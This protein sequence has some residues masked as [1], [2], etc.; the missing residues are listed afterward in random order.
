VLQYHLS[1]IAKYHLYT[2]NEYQLY[3][4]N[5]CKTTTDIQLCID[6]TLQTNLLHMHNGMTSFK[7]KIKAS[8]AH[9]IYHY[10]LKIKV[11]KYNADI[12]FN[13]QCLTKKIIPNYANTKV[14]IT[15]PATYKTQNKAQIT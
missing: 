7:F 1:F 8:Q 9:S 4:Y 3:F 12:F 2:T 6:S 5:C 10:K 14:P 13:K 15:S 11:L